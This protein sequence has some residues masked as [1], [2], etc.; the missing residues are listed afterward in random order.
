MSIDPRDARDPVHRALRGLPQPRAPRTLAPRVMAAAASTRPTRPAARP[1]LSWPLEWRLASVVA[2]AIA[3]IGTVWFWP[4]IEAS[5]WHLATR[6]LATLDARATAIAPGVS[7][8]ARLA[9][10]G[11]DT[12][13]Q[14]V[15]WIVVVWMMLMTAAC[16]AFA[17]ALERVAF[18]E[19]SQ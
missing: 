7:A 15:L 1:W 14:P 8:F 6:G 3:G 4:G 12:F 18:G 9:V 5:A 19:T 2:F 11:W 16:A 10:I 17:T 13:V